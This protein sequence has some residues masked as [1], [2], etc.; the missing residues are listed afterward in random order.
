MRYLLVA[1]GLV[2]TTT[3]FAFVNAKPPAVDGA[4]IEVRN[5]LLVVV[6]VMF[7]AVGLA[8]IDLVEA[9]KSRRP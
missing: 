7:L 1:V 8:T 9:I 3:G 2:C 6:G 5:G 4:A